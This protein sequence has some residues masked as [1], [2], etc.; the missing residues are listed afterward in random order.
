MPLGENN[1]HVPIIAI[2]LYNSNV[3]IFWFGKISLELEKT[4]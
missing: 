3:T 2:L 1:I 4:V